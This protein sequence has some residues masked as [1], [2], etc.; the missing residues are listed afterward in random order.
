MKYKGEPNLFVR[1]N[2]P[3]KGEVKFFT[4]N[5][6]GIYETNH[7]TTMA[8]LDGYC[9][10]VEVVEEVVE[11]IKEDIVEVKEVPEL[12]EL[13]Y[14]E[15]QVLYA[16]KTGESAVGVKKTVILKELEG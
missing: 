2:K 15:L 1:I 12:S 4:F 6:R 11:E 8:R 5:E 7:P 3:R 13:S 9:E 10:R 14:K 16:A